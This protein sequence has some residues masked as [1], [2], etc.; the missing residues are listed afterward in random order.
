MSMTK[1]SVA[2]IIPISVLLV[3]GLAYGGFSWFNRNSE[4]EEPHWHAAFKV[5]VDGQPV[6]FS[7]DK[8]RHVEPCSEEEN[9]AETTPEHEQIEKAHL[10]DGVGDVVHVHREGAVWRDLFE[11]LSYAFESPVVGYRDGQRI[12]SILDEPIKAY[13][14]VLFVAGEASDLTAW[15][16]SVP[17]VERIKEVE[18]QGE[19]C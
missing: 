18:A 9:E 2:L 13:D 12:D 4:T 8:Y 11:N 19:S 10:H 15:A 3:A 1:K 5:Y 7:S 16:A 17:T 14:R 6:D